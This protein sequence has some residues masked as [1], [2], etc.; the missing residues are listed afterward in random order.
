MSVTEEIALTGVDVDGVTA[1]RNDGTRG[2][3]CMRSPL[4]FETPR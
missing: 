2:M 3:R 4:R 1:P